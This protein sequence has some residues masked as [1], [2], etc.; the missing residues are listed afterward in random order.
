MA[1]DGDW[2]D[3]GS[4]VYVV[5][6]PHPDPMESMGLRIPLIDL[7]RN[8][9]RPLKGLRAMSFAVLGVE[10]HLS[11]QSGGVSIADATL[12][13]KEINLGGQVYYYVPENGGT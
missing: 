10:G 4:C 12:C 5:L 2:G 7:T 1:I 8:F 13:S 6:F 9:T 11:L 3:D